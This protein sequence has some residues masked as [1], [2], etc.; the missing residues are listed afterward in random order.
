MKVLSA[1]EVA[2]KTSMSVSNVR[3][4]A[5]NKQFPQPFALTESRYG[6]LESD[7]DEWISECIRKH[8]SGGGHG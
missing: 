2:K 5:R 3:R 8:Q 1:S 7:I 6:W 4:L